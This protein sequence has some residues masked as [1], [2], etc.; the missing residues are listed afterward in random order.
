M[1]ATET[2]FSRVLPAELPWRSEG[3]RDFFLYKDLGVKAATHG[4]VIAHPSLSHVV[5]EGAIQKSISSSSISS[6]SAQAAAIHSF[7][8]GI[9]MIVWQY[10]MQGLLSLTS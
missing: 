6:G 1:S 3:L 7:I 8:S 10:R 5:G 4:R 2:L 9:A